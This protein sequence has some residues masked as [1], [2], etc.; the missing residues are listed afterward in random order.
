MIIMYGISNCDTVKKAKKW[1]DAH[2]VSYQFHDYK[3]NGADPKV[4][5]QAI[6]A[7][8][9]D[10][11]VNKR[12]TTYRQLSASQKALVS[13]SSELAP[14]LDLL[15]THTS[16]IKRPILMRSRDNNEPSFLIGFSETTYQE[17]ICGA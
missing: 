6:S 3:K 14:I 15:L 16:V 17:F 11:V 12:G 2:D 1:L 9:I 10:T 13:A 4:L 8:N 7:T 5:S